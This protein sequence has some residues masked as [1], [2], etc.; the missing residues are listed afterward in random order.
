[1][2]YKRD[3]NKRAC[4]EATIKELATPRLAQF[5]A[6]PFK[7]VLRLT[8]PELRGLVPNLPIL[9][10]YYFVWAVSVSFHPRFGA[11]L[12]PLTL[13]TSWFLDVGYYSEPRTS[14]V[15]IRIRFP[16]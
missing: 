9:W 7:K 16:R 15:E 6:S 3:L 1:M 5:E 12:S 4:F 13:N 10:L 14:L 11:H 8:G 2:S